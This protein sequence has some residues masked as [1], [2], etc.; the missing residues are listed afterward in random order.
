MDVHFDPREVSP[1]IKVHDRY[2]YSELKEIFDN[3]DVLVAPSVWYETFGFTVLEALSYGVPV[4]MSG[5]VGAKDILSDG[6]GI[7]IEDI[8]SQKL[9]DIFK[10][11]TTYKL[12]KMNQT[13]VKEQSIM[14]IQEM[15]NLIEKIFYMEARKRKD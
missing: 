6:A 7:V 8:T 5:T 12:E 3:T 15:A 1:Y 13:I 10:N 2:T 9:Y 4:I 14:Q 11:L